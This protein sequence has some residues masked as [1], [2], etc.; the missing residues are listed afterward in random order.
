[1]RKF[2]SIAGLLIFLLSS[3]IIVLGTSVTK[4]EEVMPPSIL[5][6]IILK[7]TDYQM[8][9]QYGQQAGA[10]L[11]KVKEDQWVSALKAYNQ[12]QVHQALKANQF[13]IRKYTPQYVDF[14]K[15]MAEGAASAGYPI[16]YID[17]LLMNCTLPKPKTSTFPQGAE[18]EEFPPK[19]CSVCSAWGS[20]TKDGQLIGM[21]TLDSS[22]E[23]EYGVVIVAFPD[24]G[25]NYICGAVAGEIGDHFLMNNKG[26]FIGNSGGGG[27]PR[28]IDQDYG[29]SW[30]CSLPYLARFSNNAIEARDKILGWQINIPENFH[31]VD[32]SGNA[33]IV[34]KTANLQSVRKPGDF[35]EKDFLYST[36]NYLNKKM[37]VT[38]KGDFIKKHGGY[39]AYAAPRNLML[40]DMLH[41]YH[42]LI[43]VEFVKMM[44]RFPGN[45]PP[46]PPRGGWD[47]KICRPTNTWVS[48][49]LPDNGDN[50]CVYIC[51][52]PAGRIIHSSLASDGEK[53][54]T[55]YQYINGTHTFFKLKLAAS[56]QEVVEEARKSAKYEIA[57]AYKQFMQL[58]P[59]DNGYYNLNLV[60]SKANREYYRGK[61]AFNKALLIKGDDKLVHLAKAATAYTRSQALA[62]QVYEAL[63]PPPTSPLDL[64]LKPFGGDWATWETEVGNPETSKGN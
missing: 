35:G 28:D 6:V 63:V 51:T 7:G 18:G 26:L 17:V 52:G 4:S 5:P 20:T 31:F 24:K 48:V 27:S 64:G 46:Y 23:A 47:A 45:P 10:Y 41:N 53:M 58:K 49:S 36:N 61:I 62:R 3:N 60:Y 9:Y 34:E 29:I 15:G 22:G 25:N 42:G 43:T 21:D 30:S 12:D 44:L 38:K 33:F 39:G 14:M 55:S 40:W 16:N 1:M 57:S 13:F 59:T 54:R 2:L 11:E 50:G 56:P 8:G 37:K 19:N 32:I